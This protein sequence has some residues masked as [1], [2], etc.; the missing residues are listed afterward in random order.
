MPVILINQYILKYSNDSSFSMS[1]LTWEKINNIVNIS[2]CRPFYYVIYQWPLM[3]KNVKIFKIV[4]IL[5]DTHLDNICVVWPYNNGCNK[6]NRDPSYNITTNCQ[7]SGCHFY[8]N[9]LLPDITVPYV[10]NMCV[11]TNK[12]ISHTVKHIHIK[13][14]LR[15]YKEFD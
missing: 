6:Y 9:N 15:R 7:C 3:Y 8:I 11:L 1:S 10:I 12:D 2:F 4:C 14:T 5:T 13:F